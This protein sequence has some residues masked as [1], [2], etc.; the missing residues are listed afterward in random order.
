RQGHI[1]TSSRLPP[2]RP[3]PAGP[4]CHSLRF[5][6]IRNPIITCGRCRRN[7]VIKAKSKLA[8][9]RPDLRSGNALRAFQDNPAQMFLSEG[10]GLT[11]VRL[12]IHL[13]PSGKGRGEDEGKSHLLSPPRAGH[14][15][16]SGRADDS[17]FYEQSPSISSNSPPPSTPIDT[18]APEPLPQRLSQPAEE[19]TQVGRGQPIPQVGTAP[20]LAPSESA[21]SGG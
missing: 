4:L 18:Q 17:E 7:A 5:H 12:G 21:G 2:V 1:H 16:A 11:S 15:K 3:W 10:R 20:R 14:F 8:L 6:N 13:S 19:S 9:K